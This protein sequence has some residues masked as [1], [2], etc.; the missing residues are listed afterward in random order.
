MNNRELDSFEKIDFS[1]IIQK[2][3]HISYDIELNAYVFQYNN[4]IT[5]YSGTYNPTAIMQIIC[6]ELNIE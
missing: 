1:Q 5:N 2:G 6:E 4:K 3:C